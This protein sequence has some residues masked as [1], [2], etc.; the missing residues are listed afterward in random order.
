MF[1]R[2]S[3]LGGKQSG[4]E[5]QMGHAA[6]VDSESSALKAIHWTEKNS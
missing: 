4:M 5:D 2:K 1:I 6:A 3:V